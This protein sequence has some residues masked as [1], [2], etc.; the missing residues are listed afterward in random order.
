VGKVAL[1]WI[2]VCGLL[3]VAC[4]TSPCTSLPCSILSPANFQAS[5]YPN[6]LVA[7]TTTGPCTTDAGLIGFVNVEPAVFATSPGT[8]HIVLT[9]ATGFTYSTD[10]TFTEYS[11][12]CDCPN[13][14][15]PTGAALQSGVA[16]PILIHNP[17]DTC[18]AV[19]DAA[20]E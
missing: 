18:V 16:A 9:F 8:C 7:V 3:V 19:P 5:C 20:R 2:A 4:N 6:D 14:I 11:P 12:G 13:Y 10:V 17:P 15:G 1:G